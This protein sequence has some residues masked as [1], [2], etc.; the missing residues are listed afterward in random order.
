[1]PVKAALNLKDPE[2]QDHGQDPLAIPVLRTGLTCARRRAPLDPLGLHLRSCPGQTRRR[3]DVVERAL[4]Q[5]LSHD[6]F[7]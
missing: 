4:Q 6:G 7:T 3:H 2:K 1:M 5:E